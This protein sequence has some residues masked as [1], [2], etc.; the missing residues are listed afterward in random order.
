MSSAAV[1]LRL[2]AMR[3]LGLVS[4]VLMK[5][6][7]ERLKAQTDTY[8]TDEKAGFR[9]YRNTI[10]Q[11]LILRLVAEKAYGK[12]KQINHCFID[13]QKAFTTIRHDVIWAMLK[14]Y[15][16]RRKLVA[17]IK[18]IAAHA[19]A[20]VRV[21]KELGER[22]RM[23]VGTTQGDLISSTTFIIYLE[24]IMDV[25]RDR[26]TEVRIQGHNINNLKFADDMDMIEENKSKLQENMNEV[27][28]AGET[29]GLM[30]YVGKT[31]T[32]VT[33]KERK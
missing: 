31:K 1:T 17:L 32:I 8:I 12:G 21:D 28:K 26:D 16:V 4:K 14:S 5:V 27:R 6:L 15:G 9:K 11:T 22:F 10:Q 19:Q 33:G 7:Q 2:L 20:E 24:R 25:I 18:S 23:T 13:F 3:S 30:I 29:A